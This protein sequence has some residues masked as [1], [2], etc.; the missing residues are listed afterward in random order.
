MPGPSSSPSPRL[1]PRSTWP[2]RFPSASVRLWLPTRLTFFY[3]LRDRYQDWRQRRAR[4]R[5]LKLLARKQRQREMQEQ[6]RSRSQKQ[7]PTS[8]AA[9]SSTPA[10]GSGHDAAGEPAA[11]QFE[12]PL[13]DFPG[14]YLGSVP[15][16]R[17]R[18]SHPRPSQP[19]NPSCA[20]PSATPMA[21]SARSRESSAWRP[22]PRGP[23]VGAAATPA[24]R[25]LSGVLR[26]VF[27]TPRADYDWHP[28]RRSAAMTAP[29]PA[30]PCPSSRAR[31]SCRRAPC[32]TVPRRAWPTTSRS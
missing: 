11:Q 27:R 1:R 5:E 16:L 3:A 22:R 9:R 19:T 29:R 24:Q 23:S 4:A 17:A 15:R 14:D 32:C 25:H 28:G 20:A 30:P 2:R 21:K 31:G 26:S 6:G 18:Q 12:E 7:R 10:A 13:G 8:L